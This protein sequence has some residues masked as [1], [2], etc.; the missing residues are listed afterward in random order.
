VI[1]NLVGNAIKFT[2]GGLVAL[3]VMEEGSDGVCLH[4]LVSDTGIGIDPA[5]QALIFDPFC[6]ADGSFTRKYGGTGLGLSIVGKLVN[7][8]GGRVWVDSIPGKGST[9]HFT[10]RFSPCSEAQ[11]AQ[12]AESRVELAG[13]RTLIVDDNETNLQILGRFLETWRMEATLSV[14]SLRALSL[15]KSAAAQGR[16]FEL[17]LLDA[18]MPV[19]DGFALADQIRADAELPQ[20]TVMMLS[21]SGLN[22]EAARCRSMSIDAYVVKPVSRS[23]LREAIA[24]TL[25]LQIS[26]S[27]EQQPGARR[28]FGPQERTLTILV[29]EDNPVNEL[30]ARRMLE[31]LG[32]RVHHAPDGLAALSATEG[33]SF[34]LILMDVQMSPMDGLEATRRI[35]ENGLRVPIIA[36][37]AHAMKGDQ[38]RCLA[39]G[40][41][42]YISKPISLQELSRTL[43]MT[44]TSSKFS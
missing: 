27:S 44:T 34:D 19:M 8:M 33:H 16:P 31:S 25:G 23:D 12:R 39:A 5:K 40:M 18:N 32:H 43:E 20:A 35:R 15:M 22:A 9:F 1:T 38:E 24:T 4:F 10:A 6:Q 14:S 11:P 3:K 29:A 28:Q 26:T 42:G 41:D 37:T 17:V 2:E 13:I 30:V 36:M 21:S 7:L